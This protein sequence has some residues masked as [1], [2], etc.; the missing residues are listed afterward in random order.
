MRK[1]LFVQKF[2]FQLFIFSQFDITRAKL[3]IE[4]KKTTGLQFFFS[5][6]PH[7]RNQSIDAISVSLQICIPAKIQLSR[8]NLIFHRSRDPRQLY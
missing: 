1:N 4:K 2:D 3:W 6:F 5:F 8:K 7:T